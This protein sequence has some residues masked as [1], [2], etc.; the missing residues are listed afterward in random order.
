MYC[1][2]ETNVMQLR[3]NACKEY[4]LARCLDSLFHD[5]SAWSKP[6]SGV[7]TSQCKAG[8]ADDLL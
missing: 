1:I 5:I 4:M 8:Q 2:Y 6:S 3:G 7:N